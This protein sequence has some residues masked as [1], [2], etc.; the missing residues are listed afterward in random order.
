[1][2]PASNLPVA[3]QIPVA[4]IQALLEVQ[5]LDKYTPFKQLVR[6]AFTR[7]LIES[8]LPGEYFVHCSFNNL[9]CLLMKRTWD[10]Q[11]GIACKHTPAA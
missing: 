10:N 1:M 4:A 8:V 6:I 2:R 5:R 11:P 3:L 9:P 7:S